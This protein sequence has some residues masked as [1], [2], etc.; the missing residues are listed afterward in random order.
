MVVWAKVE[1]TGLK[2][3]DNSGREVDRFNPPAAAWPLATLIGSRIVAKEA[4]T[5]NSQG[6]SGRGGSQ[7]GKHRTIVRAS[8]RSKI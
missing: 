5:C 3:E 6:S 4:A 2:G 1:E 8:L 7:H